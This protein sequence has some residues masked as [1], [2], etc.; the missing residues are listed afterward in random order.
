MLKPIYHYKKQEREACPYFLLCITS[1][2]VK[3]EKA[4]P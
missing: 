4:P 1:T 3:T 2:R